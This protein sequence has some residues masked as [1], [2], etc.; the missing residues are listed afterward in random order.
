[1]PPSPPGTTELGLHFSIT[2][3]SWPNTP[4]LT[5]GNGMP[6]TVS[7]AHIQNSLGRLQR[8]PDVIYNFFRGPTPGAAVTSLLDSRHSAADQDKYAEQDTRQFSQTAKTMDELMKDLEIF[9]EIHQHATALRIKVQQKWA[10]VVRSR[11]DLLRHDAELD[12]YRQR[13]MKGA[14]PDAEIEQ[15]HHDVCDKARE[16]LGP[17]E[18]EYR[19][20]AVSLY[21]LEDRLAVKNVSMQRKY[22]SIRPEIPK[23]LS[24]DDNHRSE[25]AHFSFQTS[26]AMSEGGMILPTWTKSDR[27]MSSTG[28]KASLLDVESLR[29]RLENCHSSL[30]APQLHSVVE[31]MDSQMAHLDGNEPDLSQSLTWDY[32]HNPEG[33]SSSLTDDFYEDRI[34]TSDTGDPLQDNLRD[35]LLD[36]NHPLSISSDLDS[37]QKRINH[38]LFTQ[39]AIKRAGT[40]SFPNNTLSRDKG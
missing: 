6:S 35:L 23:P 29:E 28:S 9:M 13:Q 1:M 38:W 8:Q 31:S 30:E 11:N 34:S 26:P 4:S 33:V 21:K 32:P 22:R 12:L 16:L 27:I 39:T 7:P 40:A 3:D 25:S 19:K 24:E 2:S 20:L 37:T 14:P 10:D 18:D 17:V 15:W 36:S 5:E